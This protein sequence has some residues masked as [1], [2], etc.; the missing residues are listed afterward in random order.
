MRGRILSYYHNTF[1]ILNKPYSNWQFGL[2]SVPLT[3]YCIY[4]Y[5]CMYVF[6][7]SDTA[8]SEKLNFRKNWAKNSTTHDV[9]SRRTISFLH[10]CGLCAT[11]SIYGSQ[12]KDSQLE[13]FLWQWF[14]FN[15]EWLCGNY[16]SIMAWRW[17]V[18]LSLYVCFSPRMVEWLRLDS[19]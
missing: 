13:R 11:A 15:E 6:C 10:W 18:I 8:C 19:S 14:S 1:F 7:S 3:P 4:I 16:Y 5:V 12:G 9:L 2:F 17:T